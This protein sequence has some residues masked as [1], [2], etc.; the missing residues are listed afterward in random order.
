MNASKRALQML[1]GTRI[2]VIVSM[3]LIVA[4]CATFAPDYEA[5]T[6]TV[7]AIRA[8]PSESLSPR[9]EIGLHIINPNRSALTLQ[10]IAYSLKLD[11]HKILTG[12]A[13]QLPTIDGYGEGDVT[14]VASTSL[15]SSIRF[16]AGLVN[17]QRDT[18]SYSLEAK[19]DV[20]SFR[21]A[22][23]VGEKGKISLSDLPR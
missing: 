15:L 11:G 20:G 1:R 17:E 7:S 12:V 21:P 2:P 19:L 18:V 3:A 4:G 9:F 10:G 5:P 22:I 8:L 23:H 16:F 13:N 6:V 14:L